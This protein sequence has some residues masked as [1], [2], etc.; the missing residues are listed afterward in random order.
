MNRAAMN[1][2]NIRVGT[3]VTGPLW[4]EPL[5]VLATVDLGTSVKLVCKGLRTGLVR[6]SGPDP[7]PA[8]AAPVLAGREP[9]VASGKLRPPPGKCSC[10]RH[11]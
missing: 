6:V 9:F 7:R 10:P 2:E 8:R 5:E 11:R 3:V 1:I 4:P